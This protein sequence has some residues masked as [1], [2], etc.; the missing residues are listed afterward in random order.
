MPYTLTSNA[1]V[2]DDIG[3]ADVMLDLRHRRRPAGGGPPAPAAGGARGAAAPGRS[4]STRAGRAS[5][6]AR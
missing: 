3:F 6:P 4:I 1:Y 2:G 5:R